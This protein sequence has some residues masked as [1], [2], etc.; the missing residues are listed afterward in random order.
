VLSNPL[1]LPL[2]A[3]L[4]GKDPSKLAYL[5]RPSHFEVGSDDFDNIF[6]SS[7]T[8][9]IKDATDNNEQAGKT[10][11]PQEKDLTNLLKTALNTNGVFNKS[12][13][14]DDQA[15]FSNNAGRTDIFLLEEGKRNDD[16][17]SSSKK[18]K[19]KGVKKDGVPV[20]VMEFGLKDGDWWKKTDQSLMYLDMMCDKDHWP[21]LQ[22]AKPI[23]LAV[24]TVS[25]NSK[26]FKCELGI[27]LC[28]RKD[29]NNADEG[30]RN[31]SPV[32][33]TD[34]DSGGCHEGIRQA[35]SSCV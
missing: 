28:S 22:F 5:G 11:N 13:V 24:V 15:T 19:K 17:D 10:D 33:F 4:H 14:A 12:L 2:V 32:S 6:E 23:L 27:F 34:D 21:H 9:W 7:Y 1:G 20:A 26:N 31:V 35:A 29:A 3:T 25:Y 8:K 18:K 16:A 30:F